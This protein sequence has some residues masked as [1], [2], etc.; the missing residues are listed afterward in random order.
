MDFTELIQKV[1]LYALP[2]LF[3]ITVHEAAHGYA[4]RYFG[5]PTA[6][7]MGR[8]TL[9]PMSHIDPI[10]TIVM[11][12]L[13]YFATAG[14]FLFGYAKPVPVDFGRLRKPKQHMVWV[15]LAGPGVN[16]LQ[17]L[18]WGAAFYLLGAAGVSEPFFSG[19]VQGRHSGQ[20]GHVC[21]QSFPAAAAGRRSHPGRTAAMAPGGAAVAGGAL[22]LFHRHGPGPH[23]RGQQRVDAAPDG[24]EL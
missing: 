6:W 15:A 20:L 14:H 8:V 9:N 23:R 7:Q 19:D 17:A 12:A 3:A 13:L 1:A 5:D 24:P 10:G 21:L 11:P 22:G 18:G 2:V 16:F 4:A